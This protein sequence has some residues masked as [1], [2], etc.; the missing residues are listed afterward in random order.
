[1]RWQH[2]PR[3]PG[4]GENVDVRRQTVRFVERSDPYEANCI[5]ATAVIAPDSDA[6]PGTAGDHLTFAAVGWC[7]DAVDFSGEQPD[8]ICFD[9]GVQRE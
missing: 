1:V 4:L 5:A 7:V 6:T 8:T 3:L 2:D 9:E